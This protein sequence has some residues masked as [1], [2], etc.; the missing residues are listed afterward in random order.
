[1]QRSKKNQTPK[2]DVPAWA[3][4]TKPG[5]TYVL[6]MED[7]AGEHLERIEDLDRDKYIDFK[8]QLAKALGF[9]VAA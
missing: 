6:Q 9:K 2:A 3:T 4:E 1:M 8:N 7:S 5:V